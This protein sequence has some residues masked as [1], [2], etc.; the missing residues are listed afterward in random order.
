MTR[1]LT[2]FDRLAKQAAEEQAAELAR[3]KSK[4][5]RSILAWCHERFT[6]GRPRFHM[7]ELTAH[8]TAE[9]GSVA[10]DSPRRIFSLLANDRRLTYTLLSRRDSHYELLTVQLGSTP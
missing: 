7:N 6:S 4:I 1:Q 9:V 5:A 3:V 8:V 2:V 10:P